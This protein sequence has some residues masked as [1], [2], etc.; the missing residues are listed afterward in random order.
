MAAGA[1]SMAAPR[2]LGAE[3]EDAAKAL[4]LKITGLKTFIL[5]AGTD[6]NLVFVKLYTNKGI[7]GL[8]EGT[9]TGKGST[10]KAA[11]EEHE[12]YLIGKDPTD[13]EYLWQAMFRGPRYR[14]GPVLMGAIAA[15]DIALWDILGQALG[16]PIWKLLGGK[17]RDKVRVY[18]KY[19]KQP[20]PPNLSY[21]DRMAAKWAG[22]KKDGYTASKGSFLLNDSR[23]MEPSKAIR[24]GIDLLAAIREAVGPDFDILCELHGQ[25]TTTMAVDFCNRAEQ[26]HPFLVEEPTQL[27][28]L[29]ELA[30]LRAHTNVP[31]ATGERMTTKYVFAELCSR[32]LVDYV[33]PDMVHCGGITELKKIG[34]L[35]E[36]FRTELLPHNPN[37]RVCTFASLHLCMS[38]PCATLLEMGS[39]EM[40]RWDDL[41]Y[42]RGTVYEGGFALPPDRPGLGLELNE[43]EVKKHPYQPKPWTSLQWPDGAIHDR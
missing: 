15:I 11:I 26:Y 29:G 25:A 7:V 42:G 19:T 12:R 18:V 2:V 4:N 3:N 36:S 24:R 5:D 30:H 28:D 14:G 35:A 27:E 41:F 32:H 43:D 22:I 16:V 10:I 37:S 34:A 9:F 1:A 23:V 21:I 8:G 38:T 40:P 33:Q 31:L 6:E 20:I 39:S 13:I 17:A